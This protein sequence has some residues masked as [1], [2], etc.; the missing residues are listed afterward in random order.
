[1]PAT[2][3]ETPNNQRRK[4]ARWTEHEDELLLRLRKADSKISFYMFQKEYQ[5]HFPDRTASALEQ[6]YRKLENS[7]KDGR[8]ETPKSC[9]AVLKVPKRPA[10][11]TPDTMA[12]SGPCKQPR[13]GGEQDGGMDCDV[14]PP[15]QIGQILPQSHPQYPQ[16]TTPKASTT[17]P[18]RYGL[19][20]A[21]LPKAPQFQ[22]SFSSGSYRSV[23]PAAGQTVQYPLTTPSFIQAT[24]QIPVQS[25]TAIEK[26]PN[27]HPTP[28]PPAPAQDTQQT[29]S[30][31]LAESRESTDGEE[32][33]ET[34]S[35]TDS[36]LPDPDSLWHHDP[37]TPRERSHSPQQG[38]APTSSAE[39]CA[40]TQEE[41]TPKKAEPTPSTEPLPPSA[42]NLL[43]D[44]N[45]D[46]FDQAILHITVRRSRMRELRSI[47]RETGDTALL[48]RRIEELEKQLTTQNKQIQSLEAEGS[49]RVAALEKQVVDIVAQGREDRWRLENL[50]GFIE[51]NTQLHNKWKAQV[52]KGVPAGKV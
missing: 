49:L 28:A 10:A 6:Q 51:E 13:L 5:V 26:S 32:S 48:K 17:V 39:G 36:E 18:P 14:A 50:E 21:N 24:P 25:D 16:Y 7:E 33:D 47:Q 29:H 20:Q 15:I 40:T 45:E 1:M 43:N 37:P 19:Q 34:S 30:T 35:T 4:C 3:N 31:T 23:V 8:K 9:I 38:S 22:S 42:L 2:Q 46:Q 41:R 52:G 44:L 12:H 27:N 11:P